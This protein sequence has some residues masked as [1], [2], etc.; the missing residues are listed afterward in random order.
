MIRIKYLYQ[1]ATNGLAYLTAASAE[2][3]TSKCEF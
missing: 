3:S 2:N 1:P